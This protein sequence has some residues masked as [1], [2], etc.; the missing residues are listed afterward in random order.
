MA[1]DTQRAARMLHRRRPRGLDR[2]AQGVADVVLS[3]TSALS[4]Q[5]AR[6]LGPR[7]PTGAR[8]PAAESG[9]GAARRSG[10]GRQGRRAAPT[11]KRNTA[12][13]GS[14]VPASEPRSAAHRR[15]RHRW[16]AQPAARRRAGR[17]TDDGRH[18]K[19]GPW[20]STL[21]RAAREAP[22]DAGLDGRAAQ[23]GGCAGWTCVVPRARA[24]LAD[25]ARG[26]ER[27]SASQ[28]R[29]LL[30]RRL[31]PALR[32]GTVGPLMKKIRGRRHGSP[33]PP[34]IVG[35]RHRHSAPP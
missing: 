10:W 11:G 28:V 22:L 8:G 1:F 7:W 33:P 27:A 3:A 13:S 6:G 19:A 9:G 23:G 18:D 4:T 16:G 2:A 35:H 20:P 29:D 31:S 5:G 21:T 12:R 30:R 26:P 25:P 34:R 15:D 24:C 14:R 17:L 32:D